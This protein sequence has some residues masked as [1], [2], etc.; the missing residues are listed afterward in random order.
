MAAQALPQI[1][2]NNNAVKACRDN[3]KAVIAKAEDDPTRGGNI[4]IY[5]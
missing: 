5:N 3:N 2:L 4:S 1:T